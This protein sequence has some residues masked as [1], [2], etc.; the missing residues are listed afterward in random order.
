MA[1]I[2]VL[3]SV[4]HDIAHHAQSG[5][6]WVHP[7]MGQACRAAGRVAIEVQLT[8]DDPYPRLLAPVEPLKLAVTSLCQKFWDILAGH[9]LERSLVV[10]ASLIFFFADDRPD[11]YSSEVTATITASNGRIYEAHLG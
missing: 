8:S 11:D 5:L 10:S 7:H 1:S 6:S 2:K 3:Q 9:S 4:A